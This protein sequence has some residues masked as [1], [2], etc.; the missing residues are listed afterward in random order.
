M[1]LDNK[2]LHQA[3]V[4]FLQKA[5]Q[6]PETRIPEY[7]GE[8]I[9]LINY[10]LAKRAN[11]ANYS[12]K[13]DMVDAGIELCLRYIKN[14]DY[15]KYSNP[16]TFFTQYA[17]RG[18]VNVINAEELQSYFKAKLA[19]SPD[20][21]HSSLQDIDSDMHTEEDALATPYFD[22][23]EFETRFYKKKKEENQDILVG[24]EEFIEELNKEE[25][26]G[27]TKSV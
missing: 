15:V 16:H 11:F 25:E 24:L 8:C 7:I 21:L 6:D 12:Y 9:Y 5:E 13:D 26:N 2:K 3:M 18:F 14:Y 20:E 23:A 17:W 19:V 4:E 22:V 1:Y 10:N 27:C